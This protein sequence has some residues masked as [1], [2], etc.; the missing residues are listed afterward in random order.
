[1][2]RRVRVAV[3]G[4][5]PFQIVTDDVAQQAGWRE[6]VGWKDQRPVRRIGEFV[7]IG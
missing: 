6:A 1:M 5:V 7:G 2:L 3:A 4:R